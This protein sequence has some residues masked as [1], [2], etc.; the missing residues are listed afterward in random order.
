MSPA[1]INHSI[2]LFSSG[3]SLLLFTYN[4]LEAEFSGKFT[5]KVV[6]CTTLLVN[7]CLQKQYL[8]FKDFFPKEGKGFWGDHFYFDI[9]HLVSGFS[10]TNS[11]FIIQLTATGDTGNN[12]KGQRQ[13]YF[14]I[15]YLF[16][17]LPPDLIGNMGVALSGFVLGNCGSP[18]RVR[19]FGD[20]SFAHNGNVH[21][22]ANSFARKYGLFKTMKSIKCSKFGVGYTFETN[23]EI[24]S[25]KDT[26]NI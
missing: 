16:S 5:T 21:N 22:E 23:L 10:H 15:E 13:N 7:P 9:A 24:P 18:V 11:C 25:R 14:E 3:S 26:P 1:L 8:S 4:F 17:S 19:N 12:C 2:K 6:R 20:T